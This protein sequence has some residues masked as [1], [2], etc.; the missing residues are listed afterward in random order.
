MKTISEYF[1]QTIRL[2]QPSIFKHYY[3]LRAG[4]ELIA[5]LVQPKFFSTNTE[6]SGSLGE[7]EF[8][9]PGFWRSDIEI[10]EKGKE[11]SIAKFVSEKWRSRGKVEL[12]KGESFE[13]V[14]K[15]L[16]WLIEIYN[17]SQ[18]K[19]VSIK[20]RFSFKTMLEIT[21]EKKSE[22]LDKYPWVVLL[23]VFIQL[24]NERRGAVAAAS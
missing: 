1:G 3:E 10:R 22:L 14:S 6:T 12:P 7:W 18:I 2:T 13:I 15:K 11:I 21:I 8:Y 16:G 23:V 17:S 24:L 19:I 4:D 20:K 5:S 9:Q